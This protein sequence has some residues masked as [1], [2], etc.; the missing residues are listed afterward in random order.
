MEILLFVR[1]RIGREAEVDPLWRFLHQ[2]RGTGSGG[3]AEGGSSRVEL[4]A[5]IWH[6][7]GTRVTTILTGRR[8]WIR[9][10]EGHEWATGRRSGCWGGK[11][12]VGRAEDHQGCSSRRQWGW[13]P[14]GPGWS[15]AG[16]RARSARERVYRESSNGIHF[17]AGY[18]SSICFPKWV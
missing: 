17:K 13:W 16:A 4:S 11:A 7:S 3:G 8:G 10:R 1:L 5:W 6:T 15:P 12:V 2:A 18:F 14:P 9:H